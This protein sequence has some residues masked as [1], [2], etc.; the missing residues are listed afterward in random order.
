MVTLAF[1]VGL[2]PCTGALLV[3]VFAWTAGIYWAGIASTLIMGLGVFL[4]VSLIAMAS[5][6]ARHLA[7]ALAAGD[8]MRVDRFVRVLKFCGGIVITAMGGLLFAGAIS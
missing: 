1:A 8:D 4:A 3:L 7:L 2:R 5:V 6:Y